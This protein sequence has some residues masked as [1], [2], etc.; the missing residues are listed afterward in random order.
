MRTFLKKND[1][2]H[3]TEV[4]TKINHQTDGTKTYVVIS[5]SYLL[6]YATK[7]ARFKRLNIDFISCEKLNSL[8]INSWWVIKIFPW[9]RFSDCKVKLTMPNEFIKKSILTQKIKAR[10]AEGNLMISN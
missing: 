8:N 2:P 6:N 1:K 10:Y 5:K 9:D 4:L 3:L 7:K